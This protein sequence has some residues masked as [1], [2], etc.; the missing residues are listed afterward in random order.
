MSEEVKT[1]S[2][3][4]LCFIWCQGICHRL[5]DYFHQCHGPHLF[6]Q[7]SKFPRILWWPPSS[8]ASTDYYHFF[9]LGPHPRHV[10]VPRLR[11]SELQL[12]AYTTATAMLDPSHICDLYHNLQQC[13]IL[14]PLRE[15]RDWT[16]ILM[17]TSQVLN[18]LSHSGEFQGFL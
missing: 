12:L 14:N 11:V 13:W 9:F 15:T 4:A 17:N 8:L 16:W 6:K 7:L 18:P 10:G 2:S 3:C 1:Q 5:L